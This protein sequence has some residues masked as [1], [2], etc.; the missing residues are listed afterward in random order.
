MAITLLAAIL[1]LMAL[2]ASQTTIVI[3]LVLAIIC[4]VV[5]LRVRD[6]P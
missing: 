4:A 6:A 2:V 1:A 3:E 5:S